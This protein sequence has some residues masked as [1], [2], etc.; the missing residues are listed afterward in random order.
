MLAK[1]GVTDGGL[2]NDA[3]S[4]WQWPANRPLALAKS[5]AGQHAQALTGF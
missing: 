1:L 3:S 4:I 2:G 5:E